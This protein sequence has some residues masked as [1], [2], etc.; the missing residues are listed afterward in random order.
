MDQVDGAVNEGG[1]RLIVGIDAA[2][3]PTRFILQY[4]EGAPFVHDQIA[5]GPGDRRTRENNRQCPYCALSHGGW[6]REIEAR[7]FA[8]SLAVVV[9]RFGPQRLTKYERFFDSLPAPASD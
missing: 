2:D 9:G 5:L 1:R 7:G 8:E 6:P 3:I 4:G